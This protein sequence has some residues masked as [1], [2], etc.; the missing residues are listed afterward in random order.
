[1]MIPRKFEF[2]DAGYACTRLSGELASYITREDF[3]DLVD[4]LAL[5]KN[6]LAGECL[7]DIATEEDIDIIQV[8]LGGSDEEI[9]GNYT[10][11]VTKMPIQVKYH[12]SIV[13]LR[14]KDCVQYLPWGKSRPYTNSRSYNSLMLEAEMRLTGNPHYESTRVNVYDEDERTTFCPLCRLHGRVIGK[15]H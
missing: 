8:Y 5:Y 9:E 15:S 11:L 2:D 10:T 4:H 7:K 14:Y 1:M 6:I 13:P 12:H 3:E